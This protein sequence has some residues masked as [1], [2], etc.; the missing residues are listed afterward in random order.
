MM[1]PLTAMTRVCLSAGVLWLP[2]SG[3]DS[4]AAPVLVSSGADS[5]LVADNGIVSTDGSVAT[6]V[7][8]DTNTDHYFE[9]GIFSGQDVGVPDSWNGDRRWGNRGEDTLAA[10]SFTGLENGSYNVY[11]SWRNVPQANVSFAHYQMSDGGPVVDLDQSLGTTALSEL[12]LNDGTN[13]VDF[14]YLGTVN[15]TD[16]DFSVTVDDTATGEGDEPGGQDF[17]FADAIAIGPLPQMM[18]NEPCDFDLNQICDGAD[19]DALMNE[20][21][22]G[23]NDARFD[24][25]GDGFV[26]DLDRDRWLADAGPLNGF[27]GAYLV[28]DANLDGAVDAQDL[29]QLGVTWQTDNNNWTNGNFT[30][31]RSDSADLNAIGLNWQNRVA[32]SAAAVPEPSTLVLLFA[33]LLFAAALKPRRG[34]TLG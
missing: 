3:A 31:S 10:Y 18:E 17:I 34:R 16:G 33:G 9:V 5:Y 8:V 32:P 14:A 13:N 12:T 20:V 1:R 11:T 4:D 27:S 2:F 29:N 15:I 24:L 28:G 7:P 30:G 21:A 26:D 25:T 6:T 19:I 23:S 22:A